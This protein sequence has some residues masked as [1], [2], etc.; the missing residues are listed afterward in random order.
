LSGGAR[1]VRNVAPAGAA[2]NPYETVANMFGCHSPEQLEK[3]LE[4]R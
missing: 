2:L 4:A 1:G 3:A